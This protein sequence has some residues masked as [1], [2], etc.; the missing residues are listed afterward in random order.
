MDGTSQTV[1][2]QSKYTV[3]VG[4]SA[5]E[6]PAKCGGSCKWKSSDFACVH[7][8]TSEAERIGI[9][10]IAKVL[11][12]GNDKASDQRASLCLACNNATACHC[13]TRAHMSLTTFAALQ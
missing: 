1:F 3:Q 13:K 2:V 5:H 12:R 8:Q 11:P 9:N 10:Q 4:Q 6:H 7:A